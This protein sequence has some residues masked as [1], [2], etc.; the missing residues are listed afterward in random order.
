MTV[1][2]CYKPTY[3]RGFCVEKVVAFL[4]IAESWKWHNPLYTPDEVYYEG[5][6]VGE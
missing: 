1:Y 2:V 6:E 5:F 4:D 3:D